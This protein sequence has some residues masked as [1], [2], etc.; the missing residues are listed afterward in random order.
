MPHFSPSHP[1]HPSSPHIEITSNVPC[2]SH[3]GHCVHEK[4]GD[5]QE[6]SRLS[7]CVYVYHSPLDLIGHFC[8]Y[9]CG[10][11]PI[12]TVPVTNCCTVHYCTNWQHKTSRGFRRGPAEAGGLS[13]Y[14][15]DNGLF[16][17]HE[18]GHRW[19]RWLGVER[20][21]TR[22]GFAR[23]G[24]CQVLMGSKGRVVGWLGEGA[25][26]SGDVPMDGVLGMD[27]PG[28]TNRCGVWPTHRWY[29]TASSTPL[30]HGGGL[31]LCVGHT[32]LLTRERLGAPLARL[33]RQEVK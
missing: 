11:E 14:L 21:G 28:P 22:V 1:E 26:A 33:G 25:H 19:S 7:Q 16:Y 9:S 30:T 32:E 17:P 13:L 23:G 29:G 20:R 2:P 6:Y 10:V 4:W 5:V 15:I 3:R 27:F 18:G 12:A 31:F 8:P 24:V